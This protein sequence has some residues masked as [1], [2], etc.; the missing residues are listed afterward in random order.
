MKKN[1]YRLNVRFN[2][3]DAREKRI[4]DR[5]RALDKSRYGAINTFMIR[6]AE[7]AIETIERPN[8]TAFTLEDIRRVVQEALEGVTLAAPSVSVSSTE[9]KT[10]ADEAL[11][12]EALAM[13]GCCQND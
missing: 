8:Q 3:D 9:E 7:Q 12:A 11:I 10:E 13:F 2:L 1:E 4:A 6:A 5:I